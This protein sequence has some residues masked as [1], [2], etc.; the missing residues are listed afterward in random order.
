MGQQVASY[1]NTLS[2]GYGNF[3]DST[4]QNAPVPG[5][6]GAFYDANTTAKPI[7][8]ISYSDVRFE[9]AFSLGGTAAIDSRP[10]A[11]RVR[12]GTRPGRGS[13][14]LQSRLAQ[15]PASR[16]CRRAAGWCRCFDDASSQRCR[17][18]RSLHH[19]REPR[20]RS[21]QRQRRR[22]PLPSSGRPSA[23]RCKLQQRHPR[24]RVR[25]PQ[26]R[27]QQPRHRPLLGGRRAGPRLQRH[28]SGDGRRRQPRH[29]HTRAT[30][31][32]RASTSPTASAARTRTR[33]AR[34]S[35]PVSPTRTPAAVHSA[36]RFS[37]SGCRSVS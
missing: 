33:L 11:V 29:R 31:P 4:A 37:A 20:H 6:A 22:R 26:P 18:R 12:Q 36:R 3:I 9:Q 27:G 8:Q 21:R 28:L 24:H 15:L 7:P 23:E 35:L 25:H 30:K 32:S 1:P 17:R 16:R 2:N 14:L 5:I 19:Q 13:Q 10:D 34:A